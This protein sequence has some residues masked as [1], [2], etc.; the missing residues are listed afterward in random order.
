MQLNSD[1]VAE[2]E[3]NGKNVPHGA[4]VY[5][6]YLHFNS[7]ESVETAPLSG[8]R[9]RCG[10]RS[11]PQVVFVA[12]SLQQ[13]LVVSVTHLSQQCQQTSHKLSLA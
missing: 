8:E 7:L 10:W 9:D 11:H 13:L 4:E 1:K 6:F 5:F 3:R 12:E 2:E